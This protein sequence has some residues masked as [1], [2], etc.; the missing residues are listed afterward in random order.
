MIH[1]N[2]LYMNIKTLLIF[3]LQYFIL[4]YKTALYYYLDYI[5]IFSSLI[6]LPLTVTV[7]SLIFV[8]FKPYYIGKT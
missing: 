3:V 7:F 5:N 2:N 4:S 6:K 8:F 1:S